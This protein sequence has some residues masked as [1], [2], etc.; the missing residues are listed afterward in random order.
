MLK[1]LSCMRLKK[2]QNGGRPQGDPPSFDVNSLMAGIMRVESQDDKFMIN[3]TS[4]AT[5]RYGQLF[6]EIRGLP[7]LRGVNRKEFADDIGLQD[8]IF[9]MRAE[10]MIPGV[11]GLIDNA[12]DL[13]RDYPEVVDRL[14]YRPDEIAALTNFLGRQGTRNY[15]SSIL[16]DSEFTVPGVNKTPEEY[17]RLYNE[18]VRDHLNRERGK[19]T[20]TVDTSFR[21][22]TNEQGGRVGKKIKVLKKEGRPHDQAVAIALSMRDRGQL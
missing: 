14:S 18:G 13:A 15:F 20:R 3:P 10:G 9:M 21:P 2:M 11:P 6:K 8:E 5:G 17:L 19:P 22:I 1:Y 12:Y 4:T 16:D 7:Q